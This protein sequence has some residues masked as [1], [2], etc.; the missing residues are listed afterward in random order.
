MYHFSFSLSHT[1]T[2]SLYLFIRI[3]P[4]KLKLSLELTQN[5]QNSSLFAS[6]SHKAEWPS[7]ISFLF[8]QRVQHALDHFSLREVRLLTSLR[9]FS[10]NEKASFEDFWNKLIN[11]LW[12]ICVME[13]KDVTCTQHIMQNDLSS[14]GLIQS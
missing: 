5:G 10:I 13:S 11:E 9:Q 4:L 7:L 6:T 2:V 1:L 14:L 3:A 12:K 8:L